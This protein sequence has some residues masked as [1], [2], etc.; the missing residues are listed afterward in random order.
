MRIT[1]TFQFWFIAIFLI[2]ALAIEKSENLKLRELAKSESSSGSAL[3]SDVGKGKTKIYPFRKLEKKVDLTID[4]DD[5]DNTNEDEDE[6]EDDDSQDI[7]FTKVH[8]SAHE[9]KKRLNQKFSKLRQSLNNKDSKNSQDDDDADDDEEEEDLSWYQKALNFVSE[10]FTGSKSQ[11]NIDETDNDENE[12]NDDEEE[13]ENE[14]EVAEI[15]EE[16]KSIFDEVVDIMNDFWATKAKKE[17]SSKSDVDIDDD[18]EDEDD[19]DDDEQSDNKDE[20]DNEDDDDVIDNKV[21]RKSDNKIRISLNA[22]VRT[23]FNRTPFNWFLDFDDDDDDEDVFED[24]VEDDINY[25]KLLDE[26]QDLMH[27]H[28]DKLTSEEQVHSGDDDSEKSEKP[29]ARI[30]KPKRSRD[31][32]HLSRKEFEKLLLNLPSFVP[33]YSKVKNS[34]CQKHGEIFLRQLRG[35]RIWALQMMDA[36]AKIPSGLLRGNTNQ[37]GDFDLCTKISQKIKISE[38]KT[39]KMKGKYCLANIDIATAVDELKL[40]VHLI[41]GRNFIRSTINDV[42]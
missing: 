40:P 22:L 21:E 18:D 35:Q 30:E 36:T 31:E 33:D 15:K 1:P 23:V 10:K 14:T 27:K 9:V 7:P 2:L 3:R 5:N 26:E 6:D 42:S 34:E 39:I 16:D 4:D 13:D 12:D 24:T 17:Q 19:I 41:Q 8:K 20:K 32:P 29:I 38:S 25:Q 11:K 28:V 37:L